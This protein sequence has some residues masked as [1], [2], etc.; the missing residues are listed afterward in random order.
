M[1]AAYFLVHRAGLNIMK[2]IVD[3]PDGDD[4]VALDYSVFYCSKKKRELKLATSNTSLNTT[5]MP[6]E[7]SFPQRIATAVHNQC[8]HIF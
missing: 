5:A 8:S 6:E 7:S 3:E 4:Y 2:A 1:C